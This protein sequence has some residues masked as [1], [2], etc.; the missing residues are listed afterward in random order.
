MSVL[1]VFFSN[2][3]SFIFLFF[4]YYGWLKVVI[5]VVEALGIQKFSWVFSSS[6]YS[7]MFE[8]RGQRRVTSSQE[9]NKFIIE[10]NCMY[11]DQELLCLL[12]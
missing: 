2:F 8:D 11:S 5:Q 3:H 9:R 6:R 12:V 7:G 10:H 4:F 1:F